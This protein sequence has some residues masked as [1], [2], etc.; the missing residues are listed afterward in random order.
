[1][2]FPPDLAELN[3]P[4]LRSAPVEGERDCV[5]V[6]RIREAQLCVLARQ[7]ALDKVGDLSVERVVRDIARVWTDRRRLNPVCRSGE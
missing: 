6:R 7:Y 3:R 1:M 5:R 4:P 2:Y